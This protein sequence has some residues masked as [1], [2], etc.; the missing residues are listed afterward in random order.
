MA[1]GRICL[2]AGHYGKYNRSPA[3][4]NYYE[5]ER[6]WELHL[7]KKKYLEAYDFEVKTTR[8]DQKKDL[9]L[10]SRGL[11]AKGCHLFSSDHSNSTKEGTV[12]E[13]VDFVTVYHMYP[14]HTTEIDEMSKDLAE[15]LA[16][17]IAKLM[18]VKQACV[19]TS[20]K[21]SN[22][23]NGDG[24]MNDNYLGVLNGARLAG[25]P[26]VLP[27]HS[28]HTNPKTVAWLMDDKNLDAL[29]KLEAE[30]IN[31]WFEK[32]YGKTK[33]EEKTV[34][35]EKTVVV[36]LKQI[37]KGSYC[38][39]V[40]TVQRL[41]NALGYKGK[42]GKALSVDGDFGTN[43][44]YAVRAFQNAEKLAVDGIVGKNTWSALLK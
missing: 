43:T 2:D 30:I 44:D 14:D 6:M 3:D 38:A 37:R 8:A 33:E 21:S 7:R 24:Y 28:F 25:V 16:P 26:G 11:A 18:G 15:M 10:K 35:E 32:W 29:A 27:E 31:E 19:V 40:K 36:E 41:L 1:K 5:S 17:P 12:N 23:R 20:R 9:D 42:D 22:D 13:K 4:K 34:K 39:E